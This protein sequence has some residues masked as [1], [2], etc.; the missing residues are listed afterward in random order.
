MAEVSG[1]NRDYVT[2]KHLKEN[3][4]FVLSCVA[5]IGGILYLWLR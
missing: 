3:W 2:F 4:H 5:V 1:P